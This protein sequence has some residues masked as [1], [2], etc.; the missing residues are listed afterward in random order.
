MGPNRNENR[1]KRVCPRPQAGM[2]A[3]GFL[4]LAAVFGLIGL[5]GLKV[6]PLYLQ[7]MRIESVL[8]DISEDDSVRGESASRL[9][10]ELT[11]RF[12]VEGIQIPREDVSIRQIRS[13]F[14]VQV[15]HEA[16]ADFLG[17]LSFLVVVDEQ[18][19]IPR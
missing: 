8:A 6:F 5:A 13:G 17:G 3:I 15:Q 9:R 1:V 11:N 16:R 14:Q 18:V 2:T 4:F 7:K 12:Y 10:T 19:E